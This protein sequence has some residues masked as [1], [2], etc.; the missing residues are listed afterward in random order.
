ML[1]TKMFGLLF[2]AMLFLVP[3]AAGAQRGEQ[4]PDGNRASGTV[5]DETGLPVIGASVIEV[6]T[7]NGVVTDLDGKFELP[8]K[9]GA[10]LEISCIGYVTVNV[11]EGQDLS[12]VLKEDTQMLEETVVVGYGIQKKSS[13]TGAISSIKSEDLENR[14]I[15]T[16]QEGLQGKTAGVQFVSTGAD[17]GATGSIRIRGISSNASTEPLYVVDGV[18]LSNIATINPN[19]IESMEVLKDAASAAIYGA[20]AGNGVVLITTKKGSGNGHISYDFAYTLQSLAQ[21]PKVLN[22]QEYIEYM[23]EGGILTQ[24]MID[25]AWD[26]KTDTDWLSATFENS[27][28]QNHS[29]RFSGGNDKGNYYVSLGYLDNDGI[30]R[31]NNDIYSRITGAVNAEYKI[32]PWLTVGSSNNISYTK[33]NNV[34]ANSGT[35]NLVITAL[36]YDPLT[37]DILSVPNEYMQSLL[38]RGFHLVTDEDG[39]YFGISQ[40]QT[41]SSN[42]L[43]NAYK[44]SIMNKGFSINGNAY[45]NITPFKGLVFTSRFGYRLGSNSARTVSF[46]YYGYGSSSNNFYNY[47]ARTSQSIY[48][49]WENFANYSKTWNQ[50]HTLTAMAGFSFQETLTNYSNGELTASGEDALKGTAP[51]FWHLSYGADSAAK[52]LSGEDIKKAKMSWFGRIGYEYAGKYMIQASLRADAA[53]TSTLPKENRWGFFPSVSA[54]WTIS[55]EPFF[56]PLKGVFNNLKL[57]ASWGQN[58]SL[59]SLGNYEYDATIT[60]YIYYPLTSDGSTVLGHY[61]SALGNK[62]LKWET[63]E[64]FDIG[65]DA[66]LF[67]DRLTIGID[68]FDKETKDL[69]VSGVTPSNAVGGTF[70]PINAGNVYNRGFEFELGWKDTI[71]DFSYSING[72]L[73]TLKNMVTYVDPSLDF[74][75][76]YTRGKTVFTAFQKGQPIYYFRG[77]NFLGVDSETG[78][79][80]FED[81]N[82]NGEY[83]DADWTNIG[84]AIPDFTYGLTI[85][86]QYKGFDFLVFGSGSQGNQMYFRL[87]EQNSVGNKIKSVFYDGRWTPSNKNASK[88]RVN[89]L[90]SSLYNSSSAM[91][92]DGSYF[93]IKQIQLGYSIP[94]KLLSKISLSRARVYCSLD[95]YFMFTKY[96]AFSPDAAQNAVSGMGIDVGAYPAS[97]KI[98]FGLNVEF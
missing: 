14:T 2:A 92:Y 16:V 8:V 65:L 97:K 43:V 13:L 76:G 37:P 42:P 6:G 90:N 1:K 51:Q 24:G 3:F 35:G 26:G 87:D 33:R 41:D 25:N 96:P 71:G 31:G 91:V 59:A 53:D 19:D 73:A 82:G 32:T 64:Q 48:Y 58:G 77:Y 50:A 78:D 89:C 62:D 74:I 88:P 85:S 34:T 21:K 22:A 75:P 27:V 4:R 49:Q 29:L 18:R 70:S 12:I 60:S 38:D 57:R 94:K 83:D 17:P 11:T 28:M 40:L 5:V 98:V 54:G 9:R 56:E 47:E 67:N 52:T 20:E 81:I 15:A 63:S 10:Q 68:W 84:D 72:N 80:I 7:T 45:A 93:K 79:P 36:T 46:P 23:L 95:D 61:P 86:L 69:L 30:V 55:N 66:R 39:N 44:E